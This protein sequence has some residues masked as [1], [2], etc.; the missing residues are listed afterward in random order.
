ML[1][2]HH[3]SLLYLFI[4][5]ELNRLQMD[6]QVEVFAKLSFAVIALEFLYS[7]V[8]F[9]M[10]LEVAHLT[11]SWATV[12][13]CTLVWFFSC[14]DP[15]MSKE[16][17]HALDNLVT[18]FSIL[19]VMTFEK[20]ILFFKIIFLLNKIEYIIRRIRDVVWVSKHSWIELRALNDGNLIIW[21]N[22]V[23]LHE[24]LRQHFLTEG[25]G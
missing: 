2:L 9:D 22:L 16:L 18:A 5:L 8:S 21:Q 17:T 23:L 6:L 15:E 1:F 24:S 12:L 19:F 7:S 13:I 10:L 11:E 20:P 3:Q 25:K 14:V 4:L